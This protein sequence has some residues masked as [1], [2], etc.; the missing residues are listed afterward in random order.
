MSVLSISGCKR[1]LPIT[2]RLS[3]N[4]EKESKARVHY[5]WKTDIQF[6]KIDVWFQ[7]RRSNRTGGFYWVKMDVRFPKTDVRFLKPRTWKISLC[8][9]GRLIFKNGRPKFL[10]RTW[11]FWLIKN[12]RPILEIRR[13]ILCRQ[14]RVQKLWKIGRPIFQTGRPI[15]SGQIFL[16]L[17]NLFLTCVGPS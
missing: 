4:L 10:D 6:V 8:K 11:R 12:G 2:M 3:R 17:R 5:C 1:T 16:V 13:P 9:N 7:A 14:Q 15:L